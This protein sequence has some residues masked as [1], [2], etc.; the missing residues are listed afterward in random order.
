MITNCTECGGKVS[1]QAQSCPHCGAP[2]KI[3]LFGRLGNWCDELK[4]MRLVKAARKARRVK[5]FTFESYPY[6]VPHNSINHAETRK[7]LLRAKT[8][9]ETQESL[10]AFPSPAIGYATNRPWLQEWVELRPVLWVGLSRVSIVDVLFAAYCFD[11]K[12]LCDSI[13]REKYVLSKEMALDV[14][15]RFARNNAEDK[16]KAFIQRYVDLSKEN[17]KYFSANIHWGKIVETGDTDVIAYFKGNGFDIRIGDDGLERGRHVDYYDFYTWE[18]TSPLLRA[19]EKNNGTL[20]KLLLD[21]GA[22]PNQRL[23]L[24]ARRDGSRVLHLDPLLTY[25]RSREIF[26]HMVAGGMELYPAR[27]PEQADSKRYNLVE[28]L[29]MSKPLSQLEVE[30][31]NHLYEIGYDKP[32][33]KKLADIQN[34]L[35]ND[36]GRPYANNIKHVRDWIVR[37]Q[38]EMNLDR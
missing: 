21:W 10:R 33:V 15:C 9:K 27:E 22:N 23:Y 18:Y 32:L 35:D 13:I 16:V 3:G 37:V 25:I 28:T 29:W 34:S 11:D 14:L 36:E 30:F 24:S 26:D 38:P 4:L 12:E 17:K 7:K 5:N 8:F 20:V 1:D 31:M 6:S 19:I 2:L